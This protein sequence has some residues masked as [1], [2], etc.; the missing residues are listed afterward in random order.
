MVTVSPKG[1][2]M[3]VVMGYL[4][5]RI[6]E[7]SNVNIDCERAVYNYNEHTTNTDYQKF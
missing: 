4:K 1:C 7:M 3:F 2:H 6:I 5:F